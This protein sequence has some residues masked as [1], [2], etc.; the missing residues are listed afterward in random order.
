MLTGFS[1]VHLM[2]SVL[3]VAVLIAAIWWL[4][5]SLRRKSR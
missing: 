5:H 2:I 3:I 1:P 4:F